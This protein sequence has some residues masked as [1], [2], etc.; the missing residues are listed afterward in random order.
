MTKLYTATS[1]AHDD[2]T[3]QKPHEFVSLDGEGWLEMDRRAT[4]EDY[5]DIVEH[6]K[7]RD[8][9]TDERGRHKHFHHITLSTRYLR[10]W[11]RECKFH[12]PIE[13]A[14]VIA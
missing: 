8:E 7:G 14:E 4:A 9:D 6:F 2:E 11:A 5:P 3:D 10:A 1:L 12:E 13:I